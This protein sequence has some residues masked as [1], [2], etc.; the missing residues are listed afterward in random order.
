MNTSAERLKEDGIMRT[1]I[2][3]ALMIALLTGCTANR[4]QN[5]ALL[6]SLAGATVGALTF[7]NK[8]SG[9]AIG[10]GTGLLV[11]Y[12]A[13]NEMDKMD[14]Y[15]QSRV[16]DALETTPSGHQTQWVNPDSRTHYEAVPQPPRQ[17]DN[18]RVER[19]VTL[20]A[21]MADG[22]TETIYARAYRQPDGS[23]QLVQ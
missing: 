5:G 1:V 8:V 22:S 14:A 13:G 3:F 9:A 16:V 17:Y 15:D 12:I 11:G 23:W 20:K 19:D 4:A 2:A 10:A 18:G 7:K 21:R 6:G